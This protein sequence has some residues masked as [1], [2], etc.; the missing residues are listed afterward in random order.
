MLLL[1]AETLPEGPAWTY[2]LKLDGYRALT[3]KTSGTVRLRGRVRAVD[4][5]PDR[6]P[7]RPDGAPIYPGWEFAPRE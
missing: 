2:E 7:E 5:E 4:H 3:I 1:S 6:S